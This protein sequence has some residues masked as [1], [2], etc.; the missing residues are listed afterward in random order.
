MV[1]IRTSQ[2][3]VTR[4]NNYRHGYPPMLFRTVIPDCSASLAAGIPK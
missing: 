4:D 2:L 3:Y 1:I